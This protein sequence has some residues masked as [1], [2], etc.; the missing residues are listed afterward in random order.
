MTNKKVAVVTVT[1]NTEEDTRILLRSLEKVSV[2]DFRLEIVIV[3]NGSKE[4]FILSDREKKLPIDLIRIEPNRGFTGGYNKGMQEALDRGADYVLI[5]NND[6]LMEADLIK[7]LLAVLESDAKIGVTTPKIYFAKGHEFHKEKYKKEDLGHVFWFAGGSTDWDNVIT[8]HRGVDEVDT[9]QYDKMQQTDFATGCCMLFKR[10]VLEKA[11]L[12]DNKFFLYY[13][14]ADLN[15]RIKKA[16]YTI[17]YVPSAVLTHVNAASTGGSGS[18]LQDYYITRNRMLFGMK[19]APLR[20]KIALLR[21]SMRLFFS[22]RANQKRG[23]LDFYLCR[24]NKGTF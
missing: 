19:Y 5:V 23:I 1:Y 15:E 11:G 6:T 22:G 9:G 12:F 7:N 14:D 3:D 8:K 16:G 10:E 24:F 2:Q 4:P 13:E 17:F 18:E 21:E 20:T